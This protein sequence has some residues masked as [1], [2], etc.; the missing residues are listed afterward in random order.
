[1]LLVHTMEVEINKTME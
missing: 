1:M